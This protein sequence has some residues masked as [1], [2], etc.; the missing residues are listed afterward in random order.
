MNNK[1]DWG[2]GVVGVG[3]H[4]PQSL[5]RHEVQSVCAWHPDLPRDAVFIR[6]PPR[7]Y[8][9][10]SKPVFMFVSRFPVKRG[11]RQGL[12]ARSTLHSGSTL[13]SAGF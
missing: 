4:H 2:V 7:V 9:I 11:T 6:P 1:E 5:A 3:T 8:L 13:P 10:K 12:G